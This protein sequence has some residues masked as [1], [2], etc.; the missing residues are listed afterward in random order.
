MQQYSTQPGQDRSFQISQNQTNNTI[1][2]KWQKYDLPV[3]C[4]L[5]GITMNLR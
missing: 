2:Q 3:D 5:V 1:T 4:N